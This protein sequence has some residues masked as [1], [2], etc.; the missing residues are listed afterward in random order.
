MT[1]RELA[2]EIE[3]M[4]REHQDCD[5][6]VVLLGTQESIPA[7]DF[8]YGWNTP[9]PDSDSLYSDDDLALGINIV[10]G[11]LDEGHPYITIDF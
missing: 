7:I 8:V 2:R 3:A 10:D 6:S 1:Y 5:V 9:D 4:S 11:V